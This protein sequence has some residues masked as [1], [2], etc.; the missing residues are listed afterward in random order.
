M[1][2]SEQP[3]ETFSV[4]ALPPWKKAILGELYRGSEALE[5]QIDHPSATERLRWIERHKALAPNL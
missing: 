1:T 4:R 3:Q 2:A 5:L